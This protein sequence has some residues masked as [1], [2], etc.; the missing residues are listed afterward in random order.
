MDNKKGSQMTK[1]QTIKR[2]QHLYTMIC[3][4]SHTYRTS[5]RT[6]GWV[7]EFEA[8]KA[9]IYGWESTPDQ[10]EIWREFCQS[11]GCGTNLNAYDCLA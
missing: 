3:K 4:Y 6:H 2:L 5:D 8:I 10:N 1:Q 9:T 11:V 7:L